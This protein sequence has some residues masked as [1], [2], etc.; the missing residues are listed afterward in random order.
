MYQQI[1]LMGLFF[2]ALLIGVGCQ[3]NKE[4]LLAQ[5]SASHDGYELIWSDEFD[6]E[7]LPDSTKW[8][9]DLGD[10]CPHVC[11]WGNNELQYYTNRLENNR[12]ENGHLIIEAHKEDFET[13]G[14]TSARLVSKNKGD[15]TYGKF[16]IRANLPTGKGTW[17]AIWMLPT[18]WEYGGW[19][20]SGE[21][22]IM[23][24][25]GYNPDTI[26]GTI[27][28][29]AFNH[30][31]G[32][33]KDKGIFLN[34]S[35]EAFHTYG[36]EWTADKII[37]YIDDDVYYEVQNEGKSFK[38]W[39]FDKRFHLILNIAIGGNWGGKHGVDDTIFPQR[40][41]IDFVRVYQKEEDL[42]SKK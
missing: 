21:I 42:V 35:E 18:D 9:Y 11:G 1:S 36:V 14:F 26:F 16:E 24:H 3:Q 17:P 39:P 41:E 27:H 37:W 12:I 38:E 2:V 7:G 23:E 28:T 31:N 40:M 33:Q 20:A 32:T 8:S 22:D 13:K 6:G 29:E 15:W 30:M 25:V 10:G 34:D 4:Q 5:D 19:P